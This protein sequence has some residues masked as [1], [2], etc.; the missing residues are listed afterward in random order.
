MILKK[1][2]FIRILALELEDMRQE[3]ELE[4]QRVQK[5]L[6]QANI[7]HHVFRE[8]LALLNNKLLAVREFEQI[9]PTIRPENYLSL[10]E[11]TESIFNCF[12]SQIDFRGWVYSTGLVIEKKMNKVK[13]YILQED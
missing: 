1:R 12:K 7:A 2:N 8:N 10:E 6:G 4:I 3:I 11:L 9:L 5:V 13:A